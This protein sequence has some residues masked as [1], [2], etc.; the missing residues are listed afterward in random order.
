MHGWYSKSNHFVS[1][2]GD[3]QKGDRARLY[4]FL[5]SRLI[6]NRKNAAI[7]NA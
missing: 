6:F 1:V 2:Y 5:L 7:T 3:C 4:T